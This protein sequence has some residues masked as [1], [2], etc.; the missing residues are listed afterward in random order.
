MKPVTQI[1][2][3]SK[4]LLGVPT[5]RRLLIPLAVAA[6]AFFVAL[7]TIAIPGNTL[8]LQLSQYTLHSY[9]T[10]GVLA[11]LAA[12]FVLMNVYAY[13]RAKDSRDR[14]GVV[15]KGGVGGALGTLAS[16]F[17]AASCPM[18]VASLF[19]FLGF[20]TV[21]FL[22]RNQWWVF[23]VAIALMSVSL[24]V[25]SRKVNGTC[26]ACETGHG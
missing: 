21:G 7:P 3:A 15:A 5:Y 19:S 12:L 1:L 2:T 4:T 13:R 6:L 22:A 11:V 18:C 9:L 25:T 24:Y 23:L 14:L 17:G 20:G 26:R 8:A 10:L 16:V